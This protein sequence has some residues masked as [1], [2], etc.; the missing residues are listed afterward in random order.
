VLHSFQS[1]TEGNTST[2]GL[3]QASNKY[4][5]GVN[6][7]AGANGLGT[8]YKLNTTGKTFTVLHNFDKPTGGVPFATPTL[9]TNG[10]IYGV[11]QTGGPV[12]N[13]YGVVY[14]FDDGL[15]PFASLVVIRSGKIGDS[16]GILGQ[17]FSTATGV[18]FGTGAGTFT[19]V[20]DTYMVATVAPGSTTGNVTV[21]EPGG[22]LV[23][24][25]AFAVIP[26]IKSFS[27]KS[28]PVGT[29]V[30]ITGTSLMQTSSVTI[31]KAKATFTVDSDTQV[32]ATVGV[33]AVTGKVTLKTPGGTATAPGK[34]TV[35]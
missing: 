11:T 7:A 29:Q 34:F 33:G 16:V 5:Y 10:K 17:G 23:T 1:A 22:N 35:Q 9:H 21:L 8:L 12:N 3:V 30:T 24:P 14:S 28:G 25:Q 6:A 4:L 26:T 27:P 18:K 13:T 19:V 31:G 20:S 2:S 15:K 32:T